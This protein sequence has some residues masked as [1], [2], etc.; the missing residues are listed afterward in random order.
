MYS[1]KEQKI[2]I[3]AVAAAGLVAL[4]LL[5]QFLLHAHTRAYKEIKQSIQQLNKYRYLL[6]KD[7]T[8]QS[9]LKH[10]PSPSGK[11]QD[12]LTRILFELE[13][14][15]KEDT[16]K[17]SDMR[18]ESLAGNNLRIAIRTTG[19]IDKYIRFL[20][21]VENASLS[22]RVKRLQLGARPSSIDIDGAC[23][24]DVVQ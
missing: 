13:R 8:L 21:H 15:A 24:I 2:V 4:S 10:L 17:I 16:I 14:I 18:P 19:A 23:V 20:Y 12:K 1:F 22:M 11:K 9:A 3:L 5:A 6:K 7:E